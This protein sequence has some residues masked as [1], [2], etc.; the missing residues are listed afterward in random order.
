MKYISGCETH[1]CKLGRLIRHWS[2]YHEI[3]DYYL[4]YFTLI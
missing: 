4:K 2:N 1:V 3:F